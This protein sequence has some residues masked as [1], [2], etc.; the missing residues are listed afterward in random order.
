[1]SSILFFSIL[2]PQTKRSQSPRKIFF[3]VS[4]SRSSRAKHASQLAAYFVLYISLGESACVSL[5]LHS[6]CN[7]QLLIHI[8]Q[9][10]CAYAR[11]IVTYEIA[12]HAKCLCVYQCG[13]EFVF[14]S[15]TCRCCTLFSFLSLSLT[16]SSS[17]QCP[18]LL[19]KL[20]FYSLRTFLY[21]SHSIFMCV[22]YDT[23]VQAAPNVWRCSSVILPF[24]PPLISAP[25]SLCSISQG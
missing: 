11:A 1:M 20:T 21:V 6:S 14:V 8:S 9:W 22:M 24:F 13:C 23:V 16:L 18:L 17:F 4:L 19:L 3:A 15:V 5:A 7:W 10:Q 2:S 25:S 12:T